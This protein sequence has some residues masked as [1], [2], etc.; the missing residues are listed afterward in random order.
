MS[1]KVI[2]SDLGGVL[3]DYSFDRAI[4]EWASLASVNAD[5]LRERLV[6][7]GAWRQF[8]VGRLTE[9]EFCSHLRKLCGLRLTD[10]ELIQGWNSIYIGVDAEV[11]RLLRCVAAQGIRVVAATNTN[12]SHQRVWQDRFAGSLAFF[13]AIYSSW[14][15]GV[16]KPEPAF[17]QHILELEQ[18]APQD[19]LFIDD[20]A[21]NVDA[22]DSVGI[23]AVLYTGIDG[24]RD[25]F[26]RRRLL[27]EQCP[28]CGGQLLSCGCAGE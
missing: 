28:K 24:L 17:F 15:A 19:A 5:V 6:V 12:V 25:A 18:I 23:D 27:L 4:A 21:V 20:L 8:E 10:G 13:D 26:V 16:R 3:I 7:D 9:R 1:I 14:E 2:L 11:E 22:A